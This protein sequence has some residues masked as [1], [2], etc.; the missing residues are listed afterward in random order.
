LAKG[1][2][3]RY[4]EREESGSQYACWCSTRLAV[5]SGRRGE[6]EETK[7]RVVKYECRNP[8]YLLN[9]PTPFTTASADQAMAS[10]PRGM[11]A[12]QC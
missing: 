1:Q 2:R 3:E 10:K 9:T 7:V 11:H 4:R 12:L 6:S 5:G 8:G